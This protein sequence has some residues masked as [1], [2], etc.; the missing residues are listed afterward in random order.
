MNP[1]TQNTAVTSDKSDPNADKSD[2]NLD[3]PNLT[4]DNGKIYN[5][6]II[7]SGPAAFTAAIYASRANLAPLVLEGEPS[8]SGGQLM[9]TTD[10]ENFPGFPHGISGGELVNNMREHAVNFGTTVLQEVVT[11][12][13][14]SKSTATT[15]LIVSSDPLEPE[16]PK[17]YYAKSVIVATGA[18][19]KK[20]DFHGSDTFW[21]KGISACAVCDGALPMFRNKPLGVIGG[22][23][24]AMEEA[25]FLSKYASVV[26][27]FVRSNKLRASKIMQ[28]RVINNPKIKIHYSTQIVGAHADPQKPEV[29]GSVW[30]R[31]HNADT[32]GKLELSG[33][34]YAIGHK[35][36]SDFLGGQLTLDSD[37]YI[38]TTA[39]STKT[40]VPGVFAS[41]DVQDKKWRQAITAAGT[42]CMSALEAEHYLSS[43]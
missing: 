28:E 22:G 1:N 7:G 20:L 40:N 8:T 34:F 32:F 43:H 38:V 35:P 3:K 19:A 10:V 24:T 29:L 42:G 37:G 33:L 27:V 26:H 39:G 2:T 14:F 11:S 25:S 18:T 36:A 30:V 13:D 5:L 41:G 16:K 12:V 21:M 31:P 9:T 4:D 17:V 23:D 6:I 15:F